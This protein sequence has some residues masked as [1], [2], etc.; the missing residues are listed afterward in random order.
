MQGKK[1]KKQAKMKDET[2]NEKDKCAVVEDVERKL[3][4]IKKIAL[5]NNRSR[6]RPV[7]N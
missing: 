1:A 2:V 4:S 6:V 7:G 3:R 5:S